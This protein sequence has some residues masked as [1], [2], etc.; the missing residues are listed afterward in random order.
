MSHHGHA[1]APDYCT[2]CEAIEIH[3]APQS[4]DTL[5][6]HLC[7][8]HHAGRREAL[9]SCI[10]CSEPADGRPGLCVEHALVISLHE[11]REAARR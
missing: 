3:A 9:A 10:V 5:E 11:R 2:R 7:D 6:E 8:A 1:C 4:V